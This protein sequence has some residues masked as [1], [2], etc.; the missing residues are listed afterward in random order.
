MRD[1]LTV[2]PFKIVF[3]KNQIR[4]YYTAYAEERDLW[5]NAIKSAIGF[6]NVKDYYDIGN[7][8]QNYLNLKLG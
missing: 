7:V 6:L 1:G 5:V 8:K 4:I 3:P 2:Y